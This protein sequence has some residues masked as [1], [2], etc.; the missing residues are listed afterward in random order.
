SYAPVVSN[1]EYRVSSIEH[2]VGGWGKIPTMK[3]D[4]RHVDDVIIVDLEGRL[5]MGVGD[6]L[7]RDVM[8]ELIAEDWKKIL[9]NLRKVTI[10]DSSGIGEVVS[11]WKL[12]RR[13]GAS[14]KLLRPAPQIQRTLKLT[15]LLPLL[16]VFEEE[17]EGIASFQ[18]A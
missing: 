2:R 9:L 5:V 8:N 14:V 18:S 7:L 11:S 15:Q 17:A 6:E 4:V 3:V 10:I 16:E 1:I 12:G 13:F